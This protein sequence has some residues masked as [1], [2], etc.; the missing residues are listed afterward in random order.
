MKALTRDRARIWRSLQLILILLTFCL[1]FGHGITLGEND[2][3][4][5]P[6]Y[7]LRQTLAIAISRMHQPPASGY[8]AY[9]SVVDSL[10]ENGFAVFQEDKGPHLDVNGWNALFKDT[11][12]LDR[13]LRQAADTSVDPSLPP[14]IIRGNELGFADYAYLAFRVFGLHFASFYYLYFLL[15]GLSCALFIGQFWRSPF[16]LFLLSTYLAGLFFLENYAQSQGEQLATLANSRLFEAL[17]LLPAM[18]VF[19]VMWRREALRWPTVATV[20]GQSLL[21]AFLSDCRTTALWQVAMIVAL[22]GALVLA[23]ILATRRWTATWKK[24]LMPAWPAAVVV[25]ILAVQMGLIN[26]SADSRYREEPEEHLVWHEILRGLLETNIEL[27]RIYLGKVIGLGTDTDQMAYSAVIKYMDDHHDVSSPIAVVDHGRVVSIDLTRSNAAYDN[28]AKS[29]V[30]NIMV[31][32]PILVLATIPEKFAEQLNSYFLHRALRIKNLLIAAMLSTLAGVLWLGTNV[33][34]LAVR[35]VTFSV[36]AA[37]IVLAF[38]LVPP[39][40]APSYLS[41]G[42]LLC[43][44]VAAVVG[45]FALMNLA[46]RLARWMLVPTPR[47]QGLGTIYEP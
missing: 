17:S 20:A 39:L 6:V 12:T 22:G 10:N 38:A 35:D 11:A 36:A 19:L 24:R 21:L 42:T 18:H 25:G 23:G 32:H 1:D 41:V 44:L 45:V 40:I 7:R 2:I 31:A 14:Q 4:F 15:L 28:L 37:A 9:Q 30:L 33:G 26:W 43:F 5:Q 46:V 29:T 13:A 34:E 8:L 3:G 47:P 27:Q 16:A